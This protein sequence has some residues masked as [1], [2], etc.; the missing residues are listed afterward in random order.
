MKPTVSP[1][2]IDQLWKDLADLLTGSPVS[3]VVVL[4]A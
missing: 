2:R 1:D 4:P 3:G